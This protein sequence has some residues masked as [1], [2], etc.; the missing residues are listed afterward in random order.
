MSAEMSDTIRPAHSIHIRPECDRQCPVRLI[1]LPNDIEPLIPVNN[2]ECCI[3]MQKLDQRVL[4]LLFVHR[5]FRYLVQFF[6][7]LHQKLIHFFSSLYMYLRDCHVV[8]GHHFIIRLCHVLVLCFLP[9][10]NMH[11]RDR[12]IVK[13]KIEFR[14]FLLLFPVLHAIPPTFISFSR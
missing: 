11:F 5:C 7:K 6:P 14:F 1:S 4:R 8:K 10:M 2:C 13:R 12:Q 9:S 3:F